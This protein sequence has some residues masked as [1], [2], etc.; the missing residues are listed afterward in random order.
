VCKGMEE[1]GDGT[2]A[3]EMISGA[4]ITAWQVDVTA[5]TKHTNRSEWN[6]TGKQQCP[7]PDSI[8]NLN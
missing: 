4:S 7:N 1:G 3:C 8:S 2:G 5:L 6:N